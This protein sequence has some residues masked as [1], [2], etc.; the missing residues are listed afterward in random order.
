MKSAIAMLFS[1]LGLLLIPVLCSAQTT[2]KQKDFIAALQ[3]LMTQ[4]GVRRMVH[5]GPQSG[6]SWPG[7]TFVIE[8]GDGADI[9]E[10][11]CLWTAAVFQRQEDWNVTLNDRQ[12][13]FVAALQGLMTQ[14]GIRMIQAQACTRD[15][16]GHRFSVDFIDALADPDGVIVYDDFE[17][18][19]I[20][21]QQGVR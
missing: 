14:K 17:V 9:F 18:A 13:A 16:Q 19:E 20:S 7:H 11:S 10:L 1:L 21:A 12:R 2:D 15:G 8:F 5:L 3:S 4:H 6:V